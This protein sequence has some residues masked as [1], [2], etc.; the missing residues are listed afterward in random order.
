VF[1]IA[2]VP[3]VFMNSIYGYLPVLFLALLVL[4]SLL[5]LQMMKSKISVE[6]DFSDCECERGKSVKIGFHIANRSFLLCPKVVAKIYVSDLFGKE[7]GLLDTYFTMIPKDSTEFGFD[8]DMPHIGVYQVGLK[9]VEVFDFTGFFKK[10]LPIRGEF[11]VYSKPRRYD[12]EETQFSQE[13]QAEAMQ[14][15]KQAIVNGSDYTGVREYTLGDSMKTIHWKLSA[16]SRDYMTKI[17]ESSRQTDFA[18]V[19]DFAA[20]KNKDSEVL[21]DLNDC[22]IET[23]LSLVTAISRQHTRIS[24][25]YCNKDMQVM[26]KTAL[27]QEND[28][29]LVKDF[30][31]ITPEPTAEFPDAAAL[32]QEE[33]SRANRST[34]LIV[35]TSRVTEELVQELLRVKRQRRSPMLYYIVPAGLNS[36][37]QENLKAPL[38]Q[39]EEASVTC[40][41]VTTAAVERSQS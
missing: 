18:V 33:S 26:S 13:A 9:E 28:M 40:H 7:D 4:L 21:M 10:T 6:S 20:T 8:M 30:A 22:L 2:A 39:L 19:L 23:A 25:I 34:N 14:D 24:L 35:C 37:E 5:G 27:S 29:D 3:A 1:G 36:R 11:E 15:T 41:M 17:Y 31:V 38:R 12:I 32:V 16:H